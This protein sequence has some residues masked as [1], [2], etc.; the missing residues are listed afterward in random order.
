MFMSAET[1]KEEKQDIMLLEI[2][3]YNFIFRVA[4]QHNEE[5]AWTNAV[6]EVFGHKDWDALPDTEADPPDPGWL[7][8][9]AIMEEY[10]LNR[11]QREEKEEKQLIKK[12]RGKSS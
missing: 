12:M 10:H 7:K 4:R 3:L 5:R 1:E 9:D 2:Q 6:V 11:E 8:V